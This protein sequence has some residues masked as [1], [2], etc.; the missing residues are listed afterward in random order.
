MA[1][2]LR[3]LATGAALTAATGFLAWTYILAFGQPFGAW[4]WTEL[5]FCLSIAVCMLLAMLAAISV[6][7]ESRLARWRFVGAAPGLGHTNPLAIGYQQ[8]PPAI[9]LNNPRP[10]AENTRWHWVMLVPVCATL[11]LGVAMASANSSVRPT[12][13]ISATDVVAIARN[14]LP[15]A[16]SGADRQLLGV[17]V[18]TTAD[19][20]QRLGSTVAFEVI[21][22]TRLVYVV[23]FSAAGV[24]SDPAAPQTVAGPVVIL[25]AATG[26]VLGTGRSIYQPGS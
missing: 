7:F 4:G 23:Y 25:D 12:E 1:T 16:A 21:H 19:A 9:K 11:A 22:A 6:P 13:T 3:D 2:P 14:T 8:D 24:V 20:A 5:A 18:S 17:Q 26:I 15:A 10:V